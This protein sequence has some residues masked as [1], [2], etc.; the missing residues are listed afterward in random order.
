ML[1]QVNEDEHIEKVHAPRVDYFSRNL[2]QIF[3]SRNPVT[4]YLNVYNVTSANFFLEGIGFGLY[5]SSVGVFDLEFSYGG[6]EHALPGIVVVNKG[7]SAGL[8][9]RESIP[10]GTTYYG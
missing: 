6:H 9:L 3:H 7:N 1:A 10:V 5:H 8:V 2:E 4:V